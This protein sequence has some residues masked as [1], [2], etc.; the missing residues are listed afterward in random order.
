MTNPVEF[1]LAT[2]NSFPSGTGSFNYNGKFE[3]V[4]QDIAYE[5]DV[6]IWARKGANWENI[7]AQFAEQLGDGREIWV[8]PASNGEDEFVARYTVNGN[9]YWDNNQGKNYPFPK[10]FDDFKAISGYNYKVVLGEASIGSNKLHVI[11]AVQDIAFDKQVGIVFTTDNWATAHQA[12]AFYSGEL[13]R[14]MERWKVEV[15][16]GSV[17]EVQFA[18]FYRVLG[19]EYWDNNFWANYTVTPTKQEQWGA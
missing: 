19:G 5:K 16:V 15:N 10:A 2:S 4:V 12:P 1:G 11:I 18:I 13:E 14:G 7:P 9:T 6:S 3:I 17:S 8:A